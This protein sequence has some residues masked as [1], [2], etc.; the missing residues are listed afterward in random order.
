MVSVGFRGSST[1]LICG[2]YISKAIA[3]NLQGRVS[4]LKKFKKKKKNFFFST[5]WH[6]GSNMCPLPWKHRVL[7]TGLPG[8]PRVPF[9]SV[10]G[11]WFLRSVCSCDWIMTR[12][13]R[14]RIRRIKLSLKCHDFFVPTKQKMILIANRHQVLTICWELF[15]SFLPVLSPQQMACFN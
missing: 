4:A 14:Q 13:S 9:C 10:L 7:I 3:L 12:W 6:V 5:T 1:S 2:I 8:V 15:L 11:L